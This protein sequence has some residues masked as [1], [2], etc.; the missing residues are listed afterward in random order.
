M[1]IIFIRHAETY[2]SKNGLF[3]TTYSPILPITQKV[4]KNLASGFRELN[5]D[6]LLTSELIRSQQ[7]AKLLIPNAKTPIEI[8]TLLNEFKEPTKLGGKSISENNSYI[9]KAIEAYDKN[10]NWNEDDGESILEFVDRINR[11][12]DKYENTKHQIIVCTSHGFYMRLFMILTLIRPE[13]IDSNILEKTFKIKFDKLRCSS[14][15]VEDGF[16]RLESWNTEIS[17]LT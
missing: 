10:P 13:D 14:F 12:K 4:S 7:T 16:W 2:H 11:F 15:I 9:F 5:P 3:Q 17:F 8:E 6:L 1:R